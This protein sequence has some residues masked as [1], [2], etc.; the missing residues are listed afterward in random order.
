MA[1]QSEGVRVPKWVLV[2]LAPCGLLISFGIM[3]GFSKADVA[4]IK[5]RVA[6]LEPM[7]ANVAVLQ[8][9]MNEVKVSQ[10][11]M[12]QDMKEMQRDLKVILLKVK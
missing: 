2:I 10:S 4:G 5:N 6:A 3:L 7:T 8:S 11:E 12:R 9:A 1:Q